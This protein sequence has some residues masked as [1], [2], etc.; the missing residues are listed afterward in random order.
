MSEIKNINQSNNLLMHA[1]KTRKKHII[2][3]DYYDK[4]LRENVSKTYKPS[5]SNTVKSINCKLKLL[6]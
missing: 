5:T 3:K 4:Y 2:Q 1:D 6:A